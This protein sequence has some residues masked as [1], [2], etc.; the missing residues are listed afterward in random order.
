MAIK[1]LSEAAMGRII[2]QRRRAGFA[3]PADFWRRVRPAADEAEALVRAGALDPLAPGWSRAALLWELVC[4][5]RQPA[6]GC[7]GLFE[8]PMTP[9]ALPPDDP[10]ARLRSQF[11]V[12]GFLCTDHPMA[13]L[14]DA[15]SCRQALKAVDLPRRIGQRAVFAGWLITGKRVHTK[16]GQAMEFLTFEDETGT[17]ETTLFP[18]AY[19][20]FGHRI[21][22][23]GPYLLQGKVEQDWGAV[24]L[25]VEKAV[26]IKDK[27]NK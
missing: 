8:T 21:Q 14:R 12:L 26:P 10:L 19:R 22:D 13:V 24:T 3:D 11:A 5:Q 25:T 27:G 16:N 1:G 7:P 17:V 20:R 18:D 2:D 23:Q 9:P 6:T 15:G 4:R